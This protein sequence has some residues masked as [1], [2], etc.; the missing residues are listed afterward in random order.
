MVTL[1]LCH[2]EYH[3]NHQI[4]Y[5][6]IDPFVG[7]TYEGD[8]VE[9][10]MEGKGVMRYAD[11]GIY[12][13]GRHQQDL[14][15]EPHHRHHHYSPVIIICQGRWRCGLREGMGEI[16]F[17]NGDYYRGQWAADNMTDGFGKFT[18]KTFFGRSCVRHLVN[19]GLALPVKSPLRIQRWLVLCKNYQWL[20]FQI[21]M[22]QF[23]WARS[24][25]EVQ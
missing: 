23:T 18:C 2:T 25:G 20:L 19:F 8:W 22:E 16:V 12:E 11:G 21:L 9:G 3:G 6:D 15:H 10:A 17:H 13:V 5:T 24:L 7:D 1:V 14:R 4:F